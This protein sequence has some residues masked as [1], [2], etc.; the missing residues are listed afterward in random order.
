MQILAQQDH[1]VIV[2]KQLVQSVVER[3]THSGSSGVGFRTI[4]LQSGLEGVLGGQ[5]KIGQGRFHCGLFHL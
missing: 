2:L 4:A 5:I 1:I 3:Q